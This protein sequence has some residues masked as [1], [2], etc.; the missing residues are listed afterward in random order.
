[1]RRK[2]KSINIGKELQI[3]P[4]R[5]EAT[6]TDRL[7]S[8]LHSAIMETIQPRPRKILPQLC[9]ELGLNPAFDDPNISKAKYIE[10]RLPH[11]PER[12]RIVAGKFLKYVS[13][14]GFITNPASIHD[15]EDILWSE[16]NAPTIPRK[17]R[18]SV[19]KELSDGCLFVEGGR[20]IQ[21]LKRLWPIAT[22]PAE[23]NDPYFGGTLEDGII[24]HMMRNPND[25]DAWALFSRLG[26]FEASDR[27]FALLLELLMSADVRGD[28]SQ[29][30][31]FVERLNPIL[32]ACGVEL[33]EMGDDGGYPVFLLMSKS[34]GVAGRPKNIVF[35]SRVKP[36]LRFKDAVNNDLEVVS[37]VNIEIEDS[38]NRVLVFDRAVPATG[39]RWRDLQQW[40]A[41]LCG[42]DPKNR[43]TKVSLYRHLLWSLPESSPPQRLLFE[44]FYRSY[45][46]TFA[47]LPALLPEVWLHYDP[48]TVEQRGRDALFRQRMD[49]LMLITHDVRIVIEVDGLHHYADGKGVASPL[50]YANMVAADRDLRLAGYEIYRFGGRELEGE[51]GVRLV[52]EFFRRLFA[53]HGVRVEGP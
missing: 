38:S 3:R 14:L 42:L 28:E 22:M 51:S 44:S 30:R 45:A 15:I 50:R 33:R 41:E 49:F 13:D 31:K 29:Q 9:D 46:D 21:S 37:A 53:R 17:V 47:D 18:H 40:W 7:K 43:D 23:P 20:F 11:E 10:Q 36:D 8:L 39:L 16:Q 48:R 12:M 25:W 24:K 4:S 27:R 32:V 19:A 2:A 35:A 6:L 26:A 34:Q 52:K 5:D 1:M